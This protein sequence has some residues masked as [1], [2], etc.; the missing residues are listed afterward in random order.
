MY[1][2]FVFLHL[3]YIDYFTMLHLPL[4]QITGIWLYL[5]TFLSVEPGFGH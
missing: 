5:T 2:Y 4:F 1:F 3:P